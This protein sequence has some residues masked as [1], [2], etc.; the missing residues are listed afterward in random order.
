MSE[1]AE[2]EFVEVTVPLKVEELKQFIENKDDTFYYINYEK[3]DINEGVFFNYLSNLELP[4]DV[5]VENESYSER[6]S[7][8]KTFMETKSIINTSSLNLNVARLVLEYRGIDTQ[9]V[10]MN[11]IF[12]AKETRHF[13]EDNKELLEKWERFIESSLVYALYIT[14][15]LDEKNDIKSITKQVDDS[16]YIGLNVINLFSVPS[17]L[18]LFFLVPLK[19]E[20]AF[21]TRQFEEYMFRGQSLYEHFFNENNEM[22]ALFLG[23]LK[24]DIDN[25][26]LNAALKEI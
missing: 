5:I 16:S 12:N 23:Q 26:L 4:C 9:A 18:E 3:S 11:P 13:I 22:F 24:N 15:D 14:K 7:F 19:H 20:P 17:F 21:F 10:F 1:V 25:E 6:E 2:Q 8:I